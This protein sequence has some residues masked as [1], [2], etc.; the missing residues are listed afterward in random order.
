MVMTA[1]LF[2]VPGLSL[3]QTGGG[4]LSPASLDVD[5]CGC[6]TTFGE[7]ACETSTSWTIDKTTESG[8][9][10]DPSDQAYSFAVT[11]VEGPTGTYLTGTGEIIVTNSGEQTASLANI[12]LVL[13]KYHTGPGRGD[14]PGPSGNAW[15]VVAVATENEFA[16][17]GDTAPTA[18]GVLTATE[19]S[20][21]ILT[22]PD[23][24]DTIALTDRVVIEPTVD[25]DGDGLRD[26]DAPTP[27]EG[28]TQLSC[29]IYDND[30]DGWFDEDWVDYAD[31]DGDGAI[32]EDPY[33]DD[34][35]GLTDEDGACEDAVVINFSFSFDISDLGLDGPGDG[36]VP[37]ADDLRLDL[38]T[39][40]DSGGFRGG[41]T[42]VDID[43]DGD[44]E[45]DV[46]SVQQRHQ[47][48]PVAC[49]ERCQTVTL[50]DPGAAPV[51]E[52]QTCIA[53]TTS[54]LWGIDIEASGE[55]TTGVYEIEGWVSCDDDNCDANVTN[56]ATLTGDQCEGL[57]E[58]SPASAGFYVECGDG[59][60]GIGPGDFCSQ[61][62]GGWGTDECKGNNTACLRDGYFDDVFPS[63]V[64]VGDLDG[65]DGDGQYAI[66][67]T[68]SL[69][70]AEYLPAGGTP[71][72]LTADQTDPETTSSG[73]FGGQLVAATMNVAFDWA[74][75]GKCTLTGTCSFPH[76]PGTL[77]TLV[78]ACSVDD[79]LIGRSVNQ[80]LELASI[81]ISGGG[82][83]PGV[84]ISDLNEALAL[85]NEEFVDC[86]VVATGCL[87]LP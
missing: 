19:G 47:F 63:G 71:A 15:D 33:D 67:L 79:D 56:E 20:N 30:G 80:V 27:P 18:Y 22:D 23:T 35:D 12:A 24:N 2:S 43:C 26:E 3:A 1:F 45:L 70:V 64:T 52:G 78:Y 8:P 68:T 66:L 65:P 10:T 53:L 4:R 74:G 69:A 7:P 87:T 73:V 46:R 11:V 39:T 13:E 81:A 17:C 54:E 42:A 76:A 51:P 32:D 83:P 6:P 41:T 84:T 16:T 9:F 37:S 55:G 14:A 31:N 38:I 57:I 40:F 34:L 77:G 49:T 75:A 25:N 28:A 29:G 85:L 36:V 60:G 50:E 82:A 86:T 21:L 58:G 59:G 5:T 62:Q 44:D 48:D 72:A 61:T